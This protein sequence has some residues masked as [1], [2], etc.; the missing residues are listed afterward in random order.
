MNA[1][2]NIGA[3][4]VYASIA[5]IPP[6]LQY[7]GARFAI[8]TR[9]PFYFEIY[10]VEQSGDSGAGLSGFWSTLAMIGGAVAAPFTA[11]AS[12]AITAAVSGAVAAGTI[13]AAALD[14][15]NA[16]SAQQKQI[17][18][19]FDKLAGQTTQTFNSIQGQ[20]SISTDDVIRAEQAYQQL[21]AAAEQYGSIPYVARQWASAAYKPAYES[22][23]EQ[24]RKAAPQLR[25][26]A[27]AGAGAG[28]GNSLTSSSSN[29]GGGVNSLLLPLALLAAGYLLLK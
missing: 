10:E 17:G 11:G 1:I 23:L 24:I 19:E 2:G 27:A 26:T 5:D 14:A 12:L 4:P 22:R 8:N 15:H 16:S 18:A 29:T 13:G 20:A 28:A 7:P 21:A 6:A 3:W 25:T 9:D